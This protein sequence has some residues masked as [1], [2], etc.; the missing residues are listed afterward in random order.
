MVS[1]RQS[2]KEKSAAILREAAAA[3]QAREEASP[4]P[5]LL[6]GKRQEPKTAPGGMMAFMAERKEFERQIQALEAGNVGLQAK[7]R[8]LEGHEFLQLLDPALIDSSRW[9]NRDELNFSK[10]NADFAVLK[11]EIKSS[12]VNIQPIKVRPNDGRFEVVFGHRRVRACRELGIKVLA[13]VEDLDDQSLFA[14]MDR[15]NRARKNLSPY[16]QGAMY[17][18]ALDEGLFKTQAALQEAI[19][20]SQGAISKTMALAALPDV[21]VDAF[22][23]KLDLQFRHAQVLSRLLEK[24]AKAVLD[25]AKELAKASPKLDAGRVVQALSDAVKPQDSNEQD[26]AGLPVVAK[27]DSKGRLTLKLHKPLSDEQQKK[28]LS[29]IEKLLGS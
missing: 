8:E 27:T 28:L 14:E 25:R 15:E 29:Y 22:A 24:D 23:S 9:A 19:G 16:E 21:V 1:S 26:A 3:K 7:L 10:D 18:K 12:G 17:R 13:M 5:S 4:S 20:V 6:A 2:M 11:D